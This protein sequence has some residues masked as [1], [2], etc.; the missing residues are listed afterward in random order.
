MINFTSRN[1]ASGR[2]GFPAPGTRIGSVGFCEGKKTGEK[3]TEQG[4]NRGRAQPCTPGHTGGRRCSPP[5]QWLY[6]VLVSVLSLDQAPFDPNA[7][8]DKFYFNVEVRILI[9]HF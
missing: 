8:A 4:E 5:S 1:V 6:T 2:L 3:S 9:P 7:K